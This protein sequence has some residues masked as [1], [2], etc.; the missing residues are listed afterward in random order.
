MKCLPDPAP[1]PVKLKLGHS[2]QGIHPLRLR[3]ETSINNHPEVSSR[4][5]TLPS[6]R[7]Q[8]GGGSCAPFSGSAG[9]EAHRGASSWPLWV[10]LPRKEPWGPG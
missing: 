7:S 6:M 1:Q 5:S 4:Q 9:R 3:V 2:R 8:L 10:F